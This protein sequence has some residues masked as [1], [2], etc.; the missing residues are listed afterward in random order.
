MDFKLNEDQEMMISATRRVA[1]EFI[2]PLMAKYPSSKPL[3]KS[4]MLQ[5]FS[6]LA[7]LGITAPRLPV[8]AGGGGLDMLDYGMI[9]EQLP[10]VVA[11]ALISYEG[12]I[13]RINAGCPQEV[14][15]AYIPDLIAGRKIACTANTESEAGSDSNN[16]KTRLEIEGEYGYITGRKIWITNASICDVINVSCSSGTDENGRPLTRRVLVDLAQSKAEITEIP[17][18]GLQQGHLSEVVFERTRV[19]VSH[20]I[21]EPGDAGKYLTLAWNANR[22]LLGLMTVHLAQKA[23][24]MSRDYAGTRK[25]F[26]KLLGAHQLIQQDLSDIETQ[27]ISA[28]L[29]CYYALSCLDQGLRSNGSSAMAKRYATHASERA[30]NLAMQLHGGMGISQE[31]GLER[32]WRD[33][34]MFQVPD[35]TMG[36]LALIHGRELTNLAAF[37]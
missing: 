33:A 28:R 19:P 22:P 9:I 12:T 6:Q 3:P 10:P 7:E 21:G 36:I 24:D 8:E 20:I 30:I 16:I 32:M 35:G 26:G 31:L 27:V 37:R 4:A 2:E 17:V 18:T 25:Q 5:I 1:Q 23:L 13:S 34:R 29:M 14:R 11:L 15:D